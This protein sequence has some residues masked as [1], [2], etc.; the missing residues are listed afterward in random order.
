MIEKIESLNRFVKHLQQVPFLAS[1]NLYKV[2]SHF[3]E[4]DTQQVRVFADSLIEAKEKV[5][6]CKYCF[7]WKERS[8]NCIFCSDV[9]RNK[10]IICVVETWQDLLAVRSE[11]H[12]SELQSQ[13]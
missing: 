9:K 11:E 2:V 4:M 10:K 5:E 3:L 7:F 1:R 13:S 8:R 12:T 6:K